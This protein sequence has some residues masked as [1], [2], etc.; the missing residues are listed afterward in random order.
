MELDVLM[1][2]KSMTKFLIRN[3]FTQAGGFIGLI[4]SIAAIVC[5]VVFWG[6]IGQAQK[7]LLVMLGLL[8]TV[9][10]PLSIWLKGLKQLKTGPF[11]KPFHYVFSEEGI[12]VKNTAGEVDVPWEQVEKDIITKDAIYIYMNAVS[13]FIIPA[14]QCGKNFVPLAALIRKYMGEEDGE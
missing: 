4:I 13:A 2:K 7:I 14:S 8:F 1:D 3:N 9:I 6:K 12:H 11:R 10:Q 5:L